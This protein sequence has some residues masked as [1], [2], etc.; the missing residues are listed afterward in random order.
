MRLPRHPNIVPFDRLVLDEV[1]G[2]VVGF[3]SSYIP[4]GTLSENTVRV[5]K[6]EWLRQLIQ[7]VDDLNFRFGI[8]HQDIA[9]RNLL[10]D[11][12]TDTLLIF[13]FNYASRIGDVGYQQDRDD[14]KGVI[15]TLYEIIT[16]DKQFTEVPHDE[17]CSDSVAALEEWVQAPGVRLD[18]KVSEY[19]AVL[20][21]WIQSRRQ[22]R[23]IS[24]YTEAPEYFD[25]PDLPKAPERVFTIRDSQ[26]NPINITSRP[27]TSLA[28]EER[29]Q[30]RPVLSWERPLHS[31]LKDGVCVLANGQLLRSPLNPIVR[32]C[33]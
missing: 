29:A 16:Q 25:W 21:E 28:C 24:M 12:E 22:R 20:K 17:Q 7:V 26:G 18:H 30:H 10:V 8:M 9:P 11:P 19:R 13:D 3:T 1:Q 6:L 23:K 14:E 31:K 27:L 33:S 2:H 5:F 4:G 15:F 32:Q